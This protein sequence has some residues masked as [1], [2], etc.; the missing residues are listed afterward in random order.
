M[1]EKNYFVN[2][3]FRRILNNDPPMPKVISKFAQDFIWRLLQK[4][5]TKR[6]GSG[7]TNVEEI[8]QHPL[9]FVSNIKLEK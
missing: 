1:V 5:P 8:K 2:L 7:P 9:F 3:F 4:N 6:L